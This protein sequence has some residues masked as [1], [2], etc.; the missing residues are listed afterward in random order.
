MGKEKFLSIAKILV[1]V[2]IIAV[3]GA[4]W[5]VKN[6]PED[7][8]NND[9]QNSTQVA[10]NDSIN[11]DGNSIKPTEKGIISDAVSDADIDKKD[12]NNNESFESKKTTDASKEKM[13][14]VSKGTESE[15][16]VGVVTQ[17]PK[18]TVESNN[19][20]PP[21]ITEEAVKTKKTT[22]TSIN[23]DLEAKEVDLEKLKSYGLPILIDFGADACAPCKE[24]APVL[25][26]I[27]ADLQGKAIVIFVDVWKNRNAASNFPVQV[28]PTQFFFDKDGNPYVPSNPEKMRMQMYSTRDTNEHIYT[29]H[30]G[31]MTEQQIMAVFKEM[32]VE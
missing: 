5:F 20:E 13:S 7:N 23:I 1:P 10:L 19:T 28:I 29:A 15:A 31:G 18:I 27:H 32:G 30:Q 21:K 2:L 22:N 25:K 11:D 24:M 8:L 14:S 4:I 12:D 9:T 16:K 17:A 3:I 6:K 26:K